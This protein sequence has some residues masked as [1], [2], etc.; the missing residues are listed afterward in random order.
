MRRPPTSRRGRVVS[1][2]RVDVSVTLSSGLPVGA[3]YWTSQKPASVAAL[4]DC[5]RASRYEEGCSRGVRSDRT[6]L[7]PVAACR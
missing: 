5:T 7:S 6:H 3:L 4:L 2:D 1:V